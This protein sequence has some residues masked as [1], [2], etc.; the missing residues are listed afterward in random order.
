MLH[1]LPRSTHA[2]IYTEPPPTNN[3]RIKLNASTPFIPT[4]VK[5]NLTRVSDPS[6]VYASRVQG[7]HILLDNPPRHSKVTEERKVKK[8]SHRTRS[9]AGIISPK[10]VREKGLWKLSRSQTKFTSFLPLHHLW[11]DYM[12]ELLVLPPPPLRL[13]PS[14]GNH[15]TPNGPAMQ[16]KLVKADFHGALLSVRQSKN[17][18]LIGLSGLIVHETENAFKIIT[19]EDKLKLIP[20]QHSIFAFAVPLYSTSSSYNRHDAHENGHNDSEKSA[21]K[22]I[23]DYPSAEFELHGNQFCFRA[24]DRA[25]RKFKH[26]ETIEL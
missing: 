21:D 5:D 22:T 16:A 18:C 7:R 14:I 23:S 26:K 12:S 1:P 6:Q 11:L 10:E 17:P 15:P 9:N 25:S 24:S 20:K 4:Y 3:K 13:E 2:D 8:G 19:K